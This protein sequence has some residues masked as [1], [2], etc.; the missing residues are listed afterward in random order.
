MADFME[1]Y[2]GEEND[3]VEND[4]PTFSAGCQEGDTLEV[5]VN[6]ALG[7]HENGQR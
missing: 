5:A 3:G 6:P 1:Q 4:G 7:D 2:A